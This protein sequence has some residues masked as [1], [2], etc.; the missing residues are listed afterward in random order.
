[1]P[2]KTVE[3]PLQN[4]IHAQKMF[5]KK[6]VTMLNNPI[7]IYLYLILRND[8][9]WNLLSDEEKQIIF[10]ANKTHNIQREDYANPHLYGKGRIQEGENWDSFRLTATDEK[11]NFLFRTL[12]S[13]S[14][15]NVLEIGPGAGFYTRMICEVKTVRSYTAIE[16]GKNFLDFLQPRLDRIKKSKKFNYF[17]I[18]D[19]ITDTSLT[20]QYDTIILLSSIHHIP[21][22][23]ELFSRLSN[24]LSPGGVIVCYDPSHYI[25]RVIKLSKNFILSGYWKKDYYLTR[26]NLATH[27]MCSVGEYLKIEKKFSELKIEQLFFRYHKGLLK[28]LKC[29]IPKHWC[30]FDIGIIFKKQSY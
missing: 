10:K 5:W 21:N 8:L 12:E 23:I 11:G 17:L 18:C 19:E 28:L 20:E 2:D 24:A 30:S 27:H 6:S 29:F 4:Q 14:P 15:C 25:P 13:H 9:S 22:R 3:M 16:M 1:M 7:G 26:Q